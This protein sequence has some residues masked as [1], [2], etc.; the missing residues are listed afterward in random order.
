MK[1]RNDDINKKDKVSGEN[2]IELTYKEKNIERDVESLNM[3][4]GPDVNILNEL[5][6]SLDKTLINSRIDHDSLE[7]NVNV[8][9]DHEERMFD[10]LEVDSR[11]I[12]AK[13][14][15]NIAKSSDMVV[16]KLENTFPRQSP[17]DKIQFALENIKILNE[18]QRKIHKINNLVD[19]FKKNMTRGKVHALS[20]MYES[21]KTPQ[22]F[23]NDLSKLQTESIKFRRRNLSLPTF[24]ERHLNYEPKIMNAEK[25]PRN[26]DNVQK[27][28][29]LQSGEGY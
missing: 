12:W 27:K 29:E 9:K 22:N 28:A 13:E 3:R 21:F 2:T 26:R 14:L 15:E 25:Y 1:K 10:S 24:V 6:D 20:S 19:V 18:I 5:Y 4:T 7:I 23:Y 17:D 16:S 11:H 8:P